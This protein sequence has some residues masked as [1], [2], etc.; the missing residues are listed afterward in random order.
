LQPAPQSRDF[1]D[2]LVESI[3]ETITTLLSREVV[4]AL[5]AHLKTNYSFSKAE[6]PYRLDTLSSILEKTFGLHGFKTISKAISKKLYTKL[7]LEFSDN[8]DRTLMEYV[9][10][11]KMKMREM[12]DQT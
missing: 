4:D 7:A 2:I 10:E 3:D 11:A 6:V 1:N 9:E 12:G 5:Y 8:P